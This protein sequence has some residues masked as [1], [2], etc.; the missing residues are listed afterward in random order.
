MEQ[1][2]RVMED[3]SACFIQ[4]FTNVDGNGMDGQAFRPQ[5]ELMSEEYDRPIL[6][7]PTMWTKH[8]ELVIGRSFYTMKS[9]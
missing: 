5:F 6:R 9:Q 8:P 3:L 7:A 2:K 4:V 1:V